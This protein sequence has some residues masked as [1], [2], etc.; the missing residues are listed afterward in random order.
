[1]NPIVPD[2]GSGV[3]LRP[4]LRGMYRLQ[5]EAA[6]DAYVL[7][8]PEGMVQLN[9]SAGEILVRCDGA[10]ELDEIIGELERLFSTSELAPDIYRFLDHA[11]LRGWLD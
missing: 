2:A 3:P 9:S 4:R 6:Q 5:W 7:L 1:M 10:H 11:R 8:Y